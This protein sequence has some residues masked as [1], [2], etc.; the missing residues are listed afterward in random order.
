MRQLEVGTELSV[1]H[2]EE[3]EVELGRH[4]RGIVV[5]AQQPAPV[6]DEVTAEE[7]GVLGAE[8]GAQR[9]EEDSPLLWA[10][11]PDGAAE[12]GQQAGRRTGQLGGRAV[13]VVDEASHPGGRVLLA[14]LGHR[15]LEH[16][17]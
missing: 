15:A 1:H 4:A 12:E 2:G 16:L 13:E 8:L 10:Q 9:R 3:V 7:D 14:Q 5:G 6:L 11:V 17:G